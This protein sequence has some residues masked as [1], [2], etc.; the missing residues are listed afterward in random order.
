VVQSN[1]TENFSYDLLN[2]LTMVTSGTTTGFVYDAVGNITY[3]SDVGTYSYPAPGAARPHAVGF[4]TA[5]SGKGASSP[6]AKR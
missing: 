5:V 1:L 6:G 2:R 3:K 4:T